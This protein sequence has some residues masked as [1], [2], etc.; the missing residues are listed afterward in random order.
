MVIWKILVWE[1]NS[2]LT[3]SATAKSGLEVVCGM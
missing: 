3:A 2:L 1:L